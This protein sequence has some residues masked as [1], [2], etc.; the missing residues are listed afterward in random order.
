MIK[1]SYI[2]DILKNSESTFRKIVLE[3][4]A[5]SDKNAK[6]ELVRQ[7]TE[8][9]TILL[10]AIKSILEDLKIEESIISRFLYKYFNIKIFKN[11]K[12]EQLIILGSQ[13]KTQYNNI[14]KE[15]K[16]VNK[17]IENIS[18]SIYNLKLLHSA[19]YQKSLFIK[20]KKILNKSKAFI[21]TLNNKIEELKE[22][23]KALK[24][25]YNILNDNF[26]LYDF[27]YKQIPRYYELQEENYLNIL[28]YK[29]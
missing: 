12:R 2:E 13:L 8:V 25:K 17:H 3:I 16:R 22:Y 7:Y 10:D 18:F 1:E 14:N 19:I 20:D 15:I 21:N 28:T 4:V 9:D 24:Q 6:I 29:G 23:E 11:K 5:K 26:K 27:I